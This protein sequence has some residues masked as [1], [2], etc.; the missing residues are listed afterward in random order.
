MEKNIIILNELKE[1]SPALAAIGYA[2]PYTVPAGYFE[3]LAAQILLK[4]N[5]GNVES[6]SLSHISKS[7]VY[8]VP[9]GYFDQLAGTILNRVKAA[10]AATPVD[11]LAILSPLL[12]RIAKTSPFSA[13]EGYFNDLPDNVVSGVQAI[14]F[15]NEELENLSPL[16]VSLRE[17]SVYETPA[18]YFEQLPGKILAKVQQQPAK[19]ISVSFRH[20]VMRYA[21]AAVV[22]GIIATASYMFFKPSTKNTEGVDPEKVAQV[23]DQEMENFLTDNTVALA[24]AGTVV[25]N[26]SISETDSKDLFA[27][28]SDDELQ[29]YL[30]EHGGSKKPITN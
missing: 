21:M 25:T 18:H 26:D 20:R 7:P 6:E 17:M 13:P 24:D 8:E 15:V 22:T 3:G 27:N 9:P 1:I 5:A 2:V 10:K 19:V 12:S 28:V 14:E 29:S 4:I 23:P 30:E 16:M 11:E